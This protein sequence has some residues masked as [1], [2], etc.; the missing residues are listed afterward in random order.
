MRARG[1]GYGPQDGAP[2]TTFA[3]SGD[4]VTVQPWSEG[5]PCDG[6]PIEPDE[7]RFAIHTGPF[8]LANG[9]SQEIVFAQGT[10][11][12]NSVT[13]LR[14]ADALAQATFDNGF[15]VASEGGPA[16][17]DAFAAAPNPIT[18]EAC[19]SVGETA[20]AVRTIL[21]DVLGRQVAV[22]HDGPLAGELRVPGAG[23]VPG[24]YLLRV[25]AD[26]V[27]RTVRLVRRYALTPRRST[28][29]PRRGAQRGRPALS[30]L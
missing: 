18:T 5:N 22:V 13:A 12:L 14:A 30:W 29:R 15:V 25:R 28:Y 11:N 19:V 21:F 17:A 27:E 24:V 8:T 1:D 9:A 2:V 3:F 6:Q 4:P 7:R 26:G 23:L 16:D 20:G 10:S